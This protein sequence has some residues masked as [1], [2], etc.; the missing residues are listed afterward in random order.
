MQIYNIDYFETYLLVAKLNLVG[1]LILIVVHLNWPLYQ[2][3]IINT[4]L[5]D[6]L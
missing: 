2:I 4:F 1:S 6:D 3:D 5:H